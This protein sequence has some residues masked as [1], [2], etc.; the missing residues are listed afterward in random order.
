MIATLLIG[1]GLV[2]ATSV[3]SQPLPTPLQKAIA[4]LDR[5]DPTWRVENLLRSLPALPEAENS[6]PRL[7]KLAVRLREHHEAGKLP[8][9]EVLGPPNERPDRAVRRN[10]RARLE[11]LK[12]EIADAH[13]LVRWPRGRFPSTLPDDPLQ[14]DLSDRQSVRLVVQ[15]LH[16]DAWLRAIEGKTDDA[17][18]SAH[19]ALHAVRSLDDDVNLIAVLTRAATFAR[20]ASGIERTLALGKGSD[21]VL[22]DLSERLRIDERFSARIALKAERDLIL[23]TAMH[24]V[25]VEHPAARSAEAARCWTQRVDD[26]M[27]IRIEQAILL[28]RLTRML[29]LAELPVP[30]QFAAETA[31]A[32]EESGP[33]TRLLLPD[34]AKINAAVRTTRARAVVLRTLIAMERYR[35]RHGKWPA[36][37][38][39]CVPAYLDKVPLDP[40]DEAPLRYKRLKDGV[41]VYSLGNNRRDDG[42][43]A[44]DD[45]VYRLW[46]VGKRGIEAKEPE[47]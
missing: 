3:S 33:L 24:H 23:R 43:N 44:V 28:R 5:T 17:L 25:E 1:L 14:R 39:D 4:E 8:L 11:P 47:Q 26:H 36:K 40:I 2:G 45:V 15:L 19:A 13:A 22:S 20:T 21:A 32:S 7:R 10:L 6:V 35:L 42:G 16:D 12:T 29:A 30:Q 31:W 27:L 37:L 38:D 34:L 9:D 18:R 46:D 41:A